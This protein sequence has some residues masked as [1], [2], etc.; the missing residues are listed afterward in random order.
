MYGRQDY[1]CAYN[2]YLH[3]IHVHTLV[4]IL[5]QPGL[6]IHIHFH[7]FLSLWCTIHV[8]VHVVILRP[9]VCTCL[10][11]YVNMSHKPVRT[12]IWVSSLPADCGMVIHRHCE[13][14]TPPCKAQIESGS[15]VTMSRK[16]VVKELG[17]LDD[18]AQ[19]LLHKVCT[20]SHYSYMYAHNVCM[21]MY[22]HMQMYVRMYITCM[23]MQDTISSYVCMYVHAYTGMQY[24]TCYQ[25]LIH[26]SEFLPTNAY[27]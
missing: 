7:F 14:R 12:C 17:D 15:Y 27:C 10:H 19:F 25:S 20:T 2:T 23:Y 24:D 8:I 6:V 13:Y 18:L 1:T 9:C 16:K 26:I 21:Y 22:V 3:H 5:F 4:H 11:I